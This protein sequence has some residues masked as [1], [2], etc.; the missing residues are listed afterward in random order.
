MEG[1]SVAETVA[2]V[3]ETGAG[4]EAGA[5]A[6]AGGVGVAATTKDRPSQWWRPVR[7][8]TLARARPSAS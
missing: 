1:A 4:E 5:S 3:A 7:S 8:A 2:E 6:A